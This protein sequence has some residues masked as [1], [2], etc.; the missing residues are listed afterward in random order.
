[1]QDADAR[2]YWEAAKT[3]RLALQCCTKCKV[4]LYPP[5]PACPHCG[6]IEISYRDLGA[7]ITGKLYSYIVTH[8]AFVP[9]FSDEVPYI[10]ALAE[11]D[12]A[13]N[14]KLLANLINC[15]PEEVR[16]GMPLKMVWQERTQEISMPQ[17]EKVY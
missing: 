7:R 10:V 17:W 3:H 6:G 9:G 16:I 8:R 11:V 2:P 13:G 5:G 15:K 14:I 12:Q 1:M 4:F